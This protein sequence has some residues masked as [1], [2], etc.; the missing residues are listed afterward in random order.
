M[1]IYSCSTE[2]DPAVTL[3]WNDIVPFINAIPLAV[4]A[5]PFPLPPVPITSNDFKDSLMNYVRVQGA[6]APV[7][8]AVFPCTQ[9]EC[10]ELMNRLGWFFSDPWFA[11][12][13]LA[14]PAN[15]LP[16]ASV[17]IPLPR[18]NTVQVVV[19]APPGRPQVWG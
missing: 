4:S 5:P 2:D 1:A 8:R 15:A 11:E 13:A 12:V 18:T 3:L 7:L 19:H 17:V 14:A 9:G 16:L 6:G 10:C